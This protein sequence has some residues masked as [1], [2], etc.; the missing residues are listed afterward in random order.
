[1]R[2]WWSRRLQSL[3]NQ[4]LR[5]AATARLLQPLSGTAVL[6]TIVKH[7]CVQLKTAEAQP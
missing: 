6:V 3:F 2:W 1:L 5:S 7:L 4:R